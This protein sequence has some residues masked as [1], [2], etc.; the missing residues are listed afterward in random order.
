MNVGNAV[1]EILR[2]DFEGQAEWRRQRAIEYPNDHRNLRAARIFDRLAASVS[3]IPSAVIFAWYE[4]FD[5]APDSKVWSEML[6]RVGFCSEPED[7]E[8]LL[9]DFIADRVGGKLA[10]PG[11]ALVSARN[12]GSRETISPGDLKGSHIVLVEDSWQVGKD[13]KDLLQS[14]GA[15]VAGPAATVAEADRLASERN[16]DVALIDF[17]LRG[18]ELAAALIQRLAEQGVSVVVISAYDVHPALT[19]RAAAVLKKPFTDTQL[20][21]TLQPLI[22]PRA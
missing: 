20:L 4:L 5:G 3:D 13:L 6:Q 9:R 8:H 15:T 22:A 17:Y 18:G 2:L 1:V 11:S 21:A 14:V 19:A 16:P 12:R 10:T 7:A